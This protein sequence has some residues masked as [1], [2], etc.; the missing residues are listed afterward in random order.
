M[1]LGW[2][3]AALVLAW[4]GPSW[5]QSSITLDARAGNPII[6]ARINDRPVRLEVDLRMG[7]YVALSNAA[8]ER[9]R[10]RRVP[11]AN[12]RVGIDGSDAS[13][14]GR[15]ARPRIEFG[16][17][18]SQSFAGIFPAPVTT[19]ADGL[20]GP[21]ALPHDVIT[22]VLGAE[23]PGA[24]DRVFPLDDPDQWRGGATV[25]GRAV[26][27]LFSTG[28]QET[29][30]NR[31]ATR[32][33]DAD[34]AIPAHGE[35][36]EVHLILGLRTLMQPITT[37]LTVEGLGLPSAMA[38]TNAPLLGADEEDDVVVTADADPPP[39]SIALGRAAL[40]RCI[41]IRVDR[42]TRAMTLRCA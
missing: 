10:V 27:V 21:G 11:F 12:I 15:I 40:A 18:D 33:F 35:L 28:A 23:Q 38:R 41:Y 20:I 1:R 36:A 39:P 25:G 7:D 8:A 13:I 5:A 29:V 24:S 26:E 14:R 30:F 17:E 31:T 22:V 2:I 16:G 6:E 34:G 19:R 3:A 4:C 42:S 32:Q 37:G 9:L